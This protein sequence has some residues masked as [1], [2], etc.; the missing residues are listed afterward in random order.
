MSALLYTLGA[1]A[2]ILI[3][4]RVKV[5]LAAAILVGTIMIGALFGLGPVE[6]AAAVGAGAIAP[7]TIVLAV[8]IALLLTLS[9]TMREAGQLEEIVALTAALLRRPVLAMAALP[10]VVGMVPMPGGALFSAPMVKTAAGDA[11]VGGATLSAANYWYRHI[12]EHWW[13]LYPGV[14][15]ASSEAKQPLGT[16]MLFLLPLGLF[17][18]VS[19]LPILRLAQRD[20]PLRSSHAGTGVARKLL[21]ATSSIWVIMLV[22]AAGKV[23]LRLLGPVGGAGPT[24]DTLRKYAPVTLGLLV[25]LAWTIRLNRAPASLLVK[26][27][28]VRSLYVLIAVVA[29]VMIFSFMLERTGAP[30]RIPE[31]LKQLHVPVAAVVALLPFIAGLV[32]GIAVG[33][34]G[35]SFPIVMGLLAGLPGQPNLWPYV[36]LAYA[37]GHLGMMLSPLHVCHVLSNR[38][39]GTAFPP[40]YRRMLP[41]AAIMAALALA[42]CFLLQVSLNGW[43]FGP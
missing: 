13:P 32:T 24:A 39:F 18:V 23:A 33:F 3:L 35:A 12:W 27:L 34:V 37:S 10:A 41:A 5:P 14:I 38:F 19:G 43:P 8:L 20:L 40:V 30:G 21:R 26:V 9:N 2:L 29:A 22:W 36:V 25:S 1:F 16:F 31:E 15:L 42:Y 11:K 4:A 17:M 28:R 7:R 6:I